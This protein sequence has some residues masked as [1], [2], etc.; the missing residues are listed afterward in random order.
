MSS[1]IKCVAVGGGLNQRGYS[2][3]ES[4]SGTAWSPRGED[5]AADFRLE[6]FIGLNNCS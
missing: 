1:E 4:I 6:A 2:P 3:S 5:I